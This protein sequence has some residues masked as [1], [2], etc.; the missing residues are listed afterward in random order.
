[1]KFLKFEFNL[2]MILLS[3]IFT[4]LLFILLKDSEMKCGVTEKYLKA[5]AKKI[6]IVSIAWILNSINLDKFLSPVKSTLLFNKKAVIFGAGKKI[7][8]IF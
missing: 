2:K 6:W 5:I 3:E 4:I 1:M 7:K 8:I